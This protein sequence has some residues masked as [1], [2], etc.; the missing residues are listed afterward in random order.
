MKPR[1]LE[2]SELIVCQQ[3]VFG[4]LMKK[5]AIISLALLPFSLTACGSSNDGGNNDATVINRFCLPG[6]DGNMW[7]HVDLS[8]GREGIPTGATC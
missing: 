8:D 7:E 3:K 6:S 2:F 1:D 5:I 4:K